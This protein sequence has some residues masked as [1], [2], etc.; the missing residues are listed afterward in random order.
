M[1]EFN[2]NKLNLL[3]GAL[4]SLVIVIFFVYIFTS[5]ANDSKL[6]NVHFKQVNA[7][8]IGQNVYLNGYPIGV[9]KSTFLTNEDAVAVLAINEDISI[10]RDSSFSLVTSSLLSESKLLFL[11]MGIDEDTYKG[12]EDIYNT[13]LALSLNDLINMLASYIDNK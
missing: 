6:Y 1:I 2:N 5:N 10:P 13:A 9:V 12:E 3:A 7:I 4:V 8:K 11:N